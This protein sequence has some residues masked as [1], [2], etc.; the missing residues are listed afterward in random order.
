MR[1][2]SVGADDDRLHY[3]HALLSCC[4]QETRNGNVSSEQGIN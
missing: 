3:R 1:R 4:W 2:Y